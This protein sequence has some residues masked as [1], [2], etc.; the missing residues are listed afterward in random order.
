MPLGTTAMVLPGVSGTSVRTSTTA[1]GSC[2]RKTSLWISS[3]TSACTTWPAG[4]GGFIGNILEL[5]FAFIEVKPVTAHISG[6]INILQPVAV[7]VADGYASAIVDVFVHHYIGIKVLIQH[8]GK[9]NFGL[10]GA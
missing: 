5:H 7:Y 9:I 6:K 8:I 3:R 10:P 4:N 2:R 1:C